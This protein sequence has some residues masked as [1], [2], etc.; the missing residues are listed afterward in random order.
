MKNKKSIV[1]L[2]VLAIIAAFMLFNKRFSSFR[3]QNNMF[4]VSDTSTI[5]RFFLA[6][7]SNNTVKLE[8]SLGG[9]WKLNDKYDVNPSMVEIMLNTFCSIDVKA[10]VAKSSR[11]TIIRLLAAKSV[12][13]EIY[14]KVYRINIFDKIKL[15]PHDKLVRTYYVG[16]VTRD[17]S[18]T[19]MLMEGSDDPYI[20]SIPGFK[21]FVTTRYSALEGDWRSHAVFNSRIPDISSLSVVFNEAQAK[22]FRITNLN[23]KSFTLV[24][25]IDGRNIEQFD[26]ITVV[27]YLSLFKSLNFENVLDDLSKHKYDSI[28]SSVP[29][30]EITLT[31][32]LGKSHTL[33]TWKRKADFDQVDLLGNP[34]EWDIERMYGLVDS[35]EYLVSLQYFVFNDVLMPLQFFLPQREGEKQ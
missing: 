27:R 3:Q 33:K 13:T 15:F 1:F 6:D 26:T 16:D 30:Y 14:Q 10:P 4:A 35:S 18:G 32:R 8:R 24:S 22:S 34:T 9:K 31:D 29:T 7:K 28:V 21:G 17:N 25:L 2:V 23:N 19:F 5:T 11:N 20:V 12:K